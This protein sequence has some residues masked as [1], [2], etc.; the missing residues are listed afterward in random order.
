MN[1]PPYPSDTKAKGWRF[2][3]DIEQVM[4]SDTW[5]VASP[6]LRPWLLMIW[7]I[8][9]QQVP[10]GSLPDDDEIIAARIGMKLAQFAKN[11]SILL[12]GWKLA[13][14]GRLYHPT[15]TQRV[16]M[17]LEI[18]N[19]ERDRK[20]A[21]RVKMSGKVPRD[22][23]GTETGQTPDGHGIDP[24]R[25]ATGTGTGTKTLKPQV[26][27][28]VGN[29]TVTTRPD[30][31][32]PP[33]NPPSR[34]GLERFPMPPDWE[35]S[36]SIATQLRLARLPAVGSP[37]YAYGLAEFRTYWA[38]KPGTERNQAEWDN[39][40]VKSLKANS[41]KAQAPPHRTSPASSK[42]AMRETYLAQA[43]QANE[44]LNGE[45]NHEPIDITSESS[46]VA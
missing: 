24:G 11:K 28:V 7:T 14:D 20:A 12:R 5:A 46:R 26:D 4:Q 33:P 6:E 1:L 17:M 9:W 39:A 30:E 25:D 45:T 43:R 8:S 41:L 34:S 19:R 40:L 22:N 16:L 10:C 29:N 42:Q 23:Q 35:P 21:Y 44:Q 36:A 18:K 2:E 38:A 37:D 32:P 15:I 3:L 13:D 27:T 31:N